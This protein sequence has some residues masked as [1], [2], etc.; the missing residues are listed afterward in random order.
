MVVRGCAVIAMVL[1]CLACLL[2]GCGK[3][4]SAELQQ[5]TPPAGATDTVP[6]DTGDVFKEFYSE[7]TDP[8][9]K[10]SPT[11]SMSEQEPQGSYVPVFTTRGAYVTQVATMVSRWLADELATELKE[12]GHP[13]YV[14][15]I[16]N[17][18]EDLPGTYYRVRIGRFA[19]VSDARAFGENI[20]RPAGY[21]FWV[22]RKSNDATVVESA[23]TP[24]RTGP[25]STP[26][27]SRS[28]PAS[29]TPPTDWGTGSSWQNTDTDKW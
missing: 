23:L 10:T 7:Q 20:L 29:T 26:V 8:E 15:E 4:K 5:T 6:S 27:P 13:A 2:S 9:T 22:D 17:P 11:F 21:D 24:S 28:T 3:K 19:T 12:K 18:R 16:Q 1:A 14:T 25:S